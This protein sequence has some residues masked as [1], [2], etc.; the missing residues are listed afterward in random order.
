MGQKRKRGAFRTWIES[1]GVTEVARLLEV[2]RETVYNWKVGNCYPR[3]DQM[4][5]I[6]RLTKGKIDYTHIIDGAAR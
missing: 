3:V 2:R 6:K 5:D 4:R 1:T